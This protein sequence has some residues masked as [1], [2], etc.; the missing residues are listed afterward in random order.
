M[1]KAAGRNIK[2]AQTKGMNE[3]AQT[4]EQEIAPEF[5]QILATYLIMYMKNFELARET[6]EDIT[7][8][9][10]SGA[11]LFVRPDGT[12]YCNADGDLHWDFDEDVTDTIST[13][14]QK[15]MHPEMFTI[16]LERGDEKLTAEMYCGF[17]NTACEITIPNELQTQIRE[18][19]SVAFYKLGWRIQEKNYCPDCAA[20]YNIQHAPPQ[21]MEDEAGDASK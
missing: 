18:V 8:K 14:A 3:E 1:K 20:K 11:T 16:G 6:N 5:Y 4:S 13:M 19:A 10:Y 9:E 17:C 12:I 2:E 21:G 15:K 7:L